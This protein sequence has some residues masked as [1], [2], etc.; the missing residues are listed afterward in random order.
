M[1]YDVR[2]VSPLSLLVL[3]SLT[4][5]F[6]HPLQAISQFYT[7]FEMIAL[8]F[9]HRTR[10]EIR[11]KFNREDKLNPK[12]ITAALARRK[13]VGECSRSTSSSGCNLC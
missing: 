9:P 8:L 10:H 7:N 13:R 11:R 1:F 3:I 5:P 4:V 12:L 2:P 6:L